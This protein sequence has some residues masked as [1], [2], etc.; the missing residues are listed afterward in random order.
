MQIDARRLSASDAAVRVRA[1]RFIVSDPGSDLYR[2]VSRR[3][4]SDARRSE[5]LRRID[6]ASVRDRYRIAVDWQAS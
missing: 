5:P 4:R 6:T 2:G 3:F 1:F